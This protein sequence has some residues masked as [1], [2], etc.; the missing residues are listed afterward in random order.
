MRKRI[1]IVGVLVL[2]LG[3][4]VLFKWRWDYE[5][6]RSIRMY[7]LPATVMASDR[8]NLETLLKQ[9]DSVWFASSSEKKAER[10][11]LERILRSFNNRRD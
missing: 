1:V 10:E 11:R 8:T 3:G 5:T 4:A 7:D 2:L 9:L 6:M